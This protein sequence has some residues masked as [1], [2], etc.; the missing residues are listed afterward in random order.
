MLRPKVVGSC[1]A[2]FWLLAAA[3]MPVT[4][5]EAYYFLWSRHLAAGYF[6]HPA[7]VALLGV[8][9]NVVPANAFVARL[10]AIAAG[11]LGLWLMNRLFKVAGLEDERTRALALLLAAGNLFGLLFGFLTTPD[12]P[13][14]VCWT[15]ALH[16]AAY[17]LRGAKSRWLTAG[18]AA[19]I[20]LNAKYTM[21]LFAFVVLWAL[22][23]DLRRAPAQGRTPWIKTPWPWAG[24]LAGLLAFTP[25]LAWNATNDWITLR[26]QM[27]HGFA[28]ERPDLAGNVLPA[29][30]KALPG[31]PELTLA[32]PFE[33]LE[34]KVKKE[35][36]KP[37]PLDDAFKA[38]NQAVGYQAAQI[39]L[40]GALIPVLGLE[41]YR[42]RKSGIHDGPQISADLRPLFVGA[43][44]LPLAVFGL[45]AL[46][47]KVE[48]NWSAM[49]V[50][51][52]AVLLVPYAAT[53]I[54]A[55]TIAAGVNVA[56][57][58]LAIVHARAGLFPTRP[59]KDRVLLET[60]GY[61][62]LA[63]L[64]ATLDAPVFA[65]TY[66]IAAA[67]RFHAPELSVRQW[68]GVSRDSELVRNPALADIRP[69]ALASSGFWLL[70]T[71]L[72]PPRLPGFAPE[73]L[74][75]LRD[76]LHAP[77][78]QLSGADARNPEVRCRKAVHTWYAARYRPH[79]D[80]ELPR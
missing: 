30:I 75:Q 78:Q 63:S 2:L 53:R 7:L 44:V 46:K 27:R 14:I 9:G 29:P 36:K 49:Y 66:Q 72:P 56:L 26:F 31:G 43:T 17:A 70:T 3:L 61:P 65:D 21:G 11:I 58:L 41:L 73:S 48:A 35:E 32:A 51:G 60:H 16:E 15:L 19:G 13:L 39:V 34:K 57:L 22:I 23:A 54:R 68:P 59:H 74:T 77:L 64:A 1:V 80:A 71:D 37:G 10:G 67:V 50:L 62:A 45:L 20:G 76:C 52:A 28:M 79:R 69:E 8:G 5:D 42:R 24:A 4:Q 33:E 6:D 40:W 12:T 38:L 25:N 47:S 18:F 55:V